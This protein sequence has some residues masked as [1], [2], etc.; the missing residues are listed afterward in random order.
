M[1]YLGNAFSLQMLVDKRALVETFSC[2]KEEC[3]NK[4]KSVIGH[5]D[6][7]DYLGVPM[8]RVQ[9]KLQEGDILYVAQYV[10]GRLPEGTKNIPE[11]DIVY[12]KIVVSYP[13]IVKKNIGMCYDSL[14]NI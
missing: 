3:L 14:S 9:T 10:G 12:F 5:Q 8:N 11:M 2:S 6:L 7:S 4:T 13:G 1:K